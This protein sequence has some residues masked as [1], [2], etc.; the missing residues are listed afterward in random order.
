MSGDTIGRKVSISVGGSVVATAR[1]KS[2]TINNSA[3]NV[4]TDGDAGIQELLAE[5][6]EQSVEVSVDG[7]FLSSDTAL[8]DEALTAPNSAAL[9]AIVFDYGTFTIT[10]NFKQTSYNEGMP[11]NDA[12]TFSASYSSSGAVVKAVV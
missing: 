5:S 8:L 6:G 3:I 9:S 7:L 10:G 2:L 12:I 1:T 11:Y 4:T